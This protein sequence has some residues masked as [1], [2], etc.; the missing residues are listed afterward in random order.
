MATQTAG[1]QLAATL[2]KIEGIGT[3][4]RRYR[5][6]IDLHKAM[7]ELIQTATVYP[8]YFTGEKNMVLSGAW[9]VWCNWSKHVDGGRIDPVLNSKIA[10][11]SPWQLANLL[12]QMVD[13]GVTN[14][15]E[16]EQFFAALRLA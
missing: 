4:T 14:T 1:Q 15:G 6:G 3:R 11:L 13:A 5:K 7:V 12:G 2:R 10:A 9:T 16:G 8:G